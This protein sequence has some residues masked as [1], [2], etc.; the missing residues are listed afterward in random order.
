MG[1]EGKPFLPALLQFKMF[2]LVSLRP[3][4][5]MLALVLERLGWVSE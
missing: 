2:L 5:E 4:W 3:P 1:N